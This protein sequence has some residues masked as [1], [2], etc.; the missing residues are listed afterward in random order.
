MVLIKT[1]GT[2]VIYSA[3]SPLSSCITSTNKGRE[4]IL[5]TLLIL[6]GLSKPLVSTLFN[7]YFDQQKGIFCSALLGCTSINTMTYRHGKHKM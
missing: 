2:S 1:L 7:Q 6:D 3:K 4:R 5:D